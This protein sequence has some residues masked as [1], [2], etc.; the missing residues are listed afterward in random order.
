MVIKT[1]QKQPS[2]QGKGKYGGG[3]EDG[4]WVFIEGGNLRNLAG[5]WPEKKFKVDKSGG[6]LGEFTGNIKSFGWK[7]NYGFITCDELAEYGD[8]FLH[9]DQKKGYREGQIVKFTCVI[10]AEGKPVAIDL[11]SGLKEATSSVKKSAGWQ[12]KKFQVDDSG[13]V[14]GEFTGN[15]KS[16]GWAKNYGFIT[17]DELAEYGDI[18]L[19]GEQ[20]KGYREG[21]IVKFTCVL[22]AEGKPVA[23][24]L[25]S[26]LKESTQ[27]AASSV[28]KTILKVKKD[29][30]SVK[31]SGWQEK[32][33]QVDDSG[34]V[35]GEFTG[36]I[37]SF[38]W[39]R[40]FGFITCD[41]LTEY[42]DI[43]LHGEQKK[44]YREGQTVKFTCVLNAEG[45]PVA[46]DLKSGLK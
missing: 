4:M 6:V 46:I 14:L 43:F 25:K 16:F 40:N 28:K 22:N 24:D 34:G 35:L 13:G 17:C 21:Q 1:I 18:F 15:I 5:A 29:S 11:K 20:K 26:G 38:G 19:H 41:Q 44:G 7:K 2:N 12:E 23:I 37:K 31:A 33:F 30:G 9:G 8:V 45:K 42:G 3:G 32:K 36:N 27:N 39:A 10:N